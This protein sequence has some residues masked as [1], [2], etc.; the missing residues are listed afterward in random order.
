MDIHHHKNTTLF[1]EQM[2]EGGFKLAGGVPGAE[3]TLSDVPVEE[4]LCILLGNEEFGLSEQALSACDYQYSIPMF[5]MSQSLNLSVSGALTLYDIARRKRD[6]IIGSG[7][8]SDQE[9][10]VELAWHLFRLIGDRRAGQY[11]TYHN[12]D[13]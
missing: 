5:G 7:D 4:P 10:R 11:L 6:H 13:L 2:A 3:M 12:G 1:L 9:R 8:F